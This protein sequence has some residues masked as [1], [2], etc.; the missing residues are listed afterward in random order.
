MK[1][2]KFLLLSFLLASA[3]AC[4]KDNSQHIIP[5]NAKPVITG[6]WQWVVSHGGWGAVYQPTADSVVTLR[7]SKDSSCAMLLNDQVEY[8][9]TFSTSVTP[10]PDSSFLLSFNHYVQL[11]DLRLQQLENIIYFKNDTMVLYD[12]LI[13]DGSSHVFVRKK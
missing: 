2:K 7:L 1:K 13:S 3:F 8:S 5:V 11:R 9:G 6:N 4:T 12:Y 10:G